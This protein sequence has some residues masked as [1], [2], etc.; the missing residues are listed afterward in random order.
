MASI[1]RIITLL[2]LFIACIGQG[3]A[4]AETKRISSYKV[5]RT[6]GTFVRKFDYTPPWTIYL[7]ADVVTTGN[8]ALAIDVDG[9]RLYSAIEQKAFN[10]QGQRLFSY[11]TMEGVICCSVLP[12]TSKAY[13][14]RNV[15]GYD[16]LL[17]EVSP[18]GT[19]RFAENGWGSS[20]MRDLC[21]ISATDYL[22]TIEPHTPFYPGGQVTIART[23][24]RPGDYLWYNWQ[25]TK[26]IGMRPTY[27]I[28]YQP[29]ASS[30]FCYECVPGQTTG[31]IVERNVTTLAVI[32][33]YA[34][35]YWVNDIAMSRDGQYLYVSRGN[36]ANASIQRLR[37]TDF[38][39]VNLI[40]SAGQGDSNI[41]YPA[42]I[43]VDEAAGLVFVVD[44][45]VPEQ[46][47]MRIVSL[48]TKFGENIHV[49]DCTD[50]YTRC[51]VTDSAG[52]VIKTTVIRKEQ[53]GDVVLLGDGTLRGTWGYTSKDAGRTWEMPG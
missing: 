51:T 46:P 47:G 28:A 7:N 50:G 35:P 43:A 42:A 18:N 52:T 32:R 13:F 17:L 29:G 5:F 36:G 4:M 27:S 24:K 40:S 12:A 23:T 37:M 2:V 9:N 14:W 20:V 53:L 30:F 38:S 34:V 22:Y 49:Y 26:V 15:S 45:N 10:Y 16:G 44:L 39:L 33:E 3:E 8:R 6:D 11:T 48:H 21:M 19:F 1:W 25:Y 41:W 31:Y